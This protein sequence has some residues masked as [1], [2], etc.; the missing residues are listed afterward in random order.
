M[1]QLFKRDINAKQ[2]DKIHC[3]LP[4]SHMNTNN[5]DWLPALLAGAT[6]VYK[7]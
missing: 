5:D 4:W 6:V 7:I 1:L 2:T 3:T